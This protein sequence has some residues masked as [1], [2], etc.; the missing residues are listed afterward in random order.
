M[1][2]LIKA[3]ALILLSF[4]AKKVRRRTF[5]SNFLIEFPL[6]NWLLNW[7][8]RNFGVYY[9]YCFQGCS[10]IYQQWDAKEQ[11]NENKSRIFFIPRIDYNYR[12]YR[13]SAEENKL[14]LSQGNI[15]N[16][17]RQVIINYDS[18]LIKWSYVDNYYN[19]STCMLKVLH[20]LD[21]VPT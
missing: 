9:F 16:T 19:M 11:Q 21:A 14:Y 12:K 20:R 17:Y 1:I 13:S 15:R 3:T 18:D 7:V 8:S 10:H 5:Q 6:S 2:I 4:A